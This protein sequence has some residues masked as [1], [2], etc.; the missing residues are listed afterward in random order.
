MFCLSS[1]LWQ[2]YRR[3]QGQCCQHYKAHFQILHLF[4]HWGVVERSLFLDY[5]ISAD[6][7]HET[8]QRKHFGLSEKDMEK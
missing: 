4:C 3:T 2:G 1:Q 8:E 6:I 5:I 7:V